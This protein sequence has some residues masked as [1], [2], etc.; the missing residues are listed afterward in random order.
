MI[1][2][3][4]GILIS[5][6]FVQT[7]IAEKK[8]AAIGID[9]W[10]IYTDESDVGN[11]VDYQKKATLLDDAALTHRGMRLNN[12]TNWLAKRRITFIVTIA[13]NTPTIYPESIPKHFKI[14]GK[15]SRYDQM[16]RFLREKTKVN[17]LDLR[18]PLLNAKKG[19]LVYLKT[20]TH[21]NARGAFVAYQEIMRYIQKL[22]PLD[23]KNLTPKELSYFNLEKK[24]YSGG[25]AS[26]LGLQ[27]TLK[28][29]IP[30]I[31]PKT[32]F[33][34]ERRTWTQKWLAGWNNVAFATENKAACPGLKLLV[35]RDSFF[36]DVQPYISEHFCQAL[37]ISSWRVNKNLIEQFKPDVLIFEVTERYLDYLD[38]VPN[39]P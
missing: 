33:K 9:G 27:N 7:A 36:T 39:V 18:P 28:E 14:I 15:I 2:V 16:S 29:E 32:P 37:F 13:P 24:T 12:L 11:L 21:W 22:R 10:L 6:I 20:D 19:N 17:F 8:K 3:A 5:L 30:V 4:A 25:L 35:F 38:N 31:V 23:T 26:V 1:R 34:A